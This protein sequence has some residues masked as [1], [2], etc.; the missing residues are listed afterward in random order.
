MGPP[1]IE[2]YLV[3]RYHLYNQVYFHK[4]NQLTQE[5]LVGALSRARELANLDKLTLS[6]PLQ[7]MLCND[8]LTVPQYVRLTDA[9]INSA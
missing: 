7:N 6:E 4:V 5:Y 2:A 3:T 1:A 9:D 8:E